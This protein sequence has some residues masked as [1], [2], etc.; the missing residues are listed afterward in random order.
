MKKIAAG[1][2]GKASKYQPDFFFGQDTITI[3]GIMKLLENCIY[4][5]CTFKRVTTIM[6]TGMRN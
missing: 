2:N 3:A 1:Y 4:K 6:A 5:L